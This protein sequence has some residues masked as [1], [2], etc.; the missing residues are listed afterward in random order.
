MGPVISVFNTFTLTPLV[1]SEMCYFLVAK[2]MSDL[3]VCGFFF[4]SCALAEVYEQPAVSLSPR[5]L[6]ESEEDD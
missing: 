2:E 5:L 3:L 1:Q 6:I 4:I